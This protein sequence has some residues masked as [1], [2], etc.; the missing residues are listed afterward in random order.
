MKLNWVRFWT[1]VSY[2]EW[3]GF[4]EVVNIMNF[5][6]MFLNPGDSNTNHN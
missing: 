5:E 3:N 4:I 2:I 1:V 6:I